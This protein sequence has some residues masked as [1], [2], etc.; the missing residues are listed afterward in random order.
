MRQLAGER[1][2]APEIFIP[3]L[4]ALDERERALAKLEE[5]YHSHSAGLVY[6]NVD[7][8]YNRLRGEPAFTRVLQGMN[9]A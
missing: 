8:R 4:L 5:A 3:P 1:Y 2:V 6:C 9:L 7:S